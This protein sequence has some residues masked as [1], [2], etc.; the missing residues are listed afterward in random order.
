MK[1]LV[2]GSREWTNEEVIRRELSSLPTGTI[3][4][5]GACPWGADV[6]VDRISRELGFE[7][8]E[9]PATGWG[10]Y[11]RGH[12]GNARNHRM[13][14]EEHQPDEPIDLCIG[15]PMNTIQWCGTMDCIQR[16]RDVDIPTKVVTE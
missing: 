4:I 3:I 14:K 1:V 5:H 7:V 11:L 9:H 6:I 8:R 10:S 13:I 16:A 15:F 12:A 2:T